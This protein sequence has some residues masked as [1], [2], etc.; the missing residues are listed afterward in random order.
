MSKTLNQKKMK[1][2]S[3]DYENPN[4]KADETEL[5]EL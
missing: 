4:T 3:V 5:F 1:F 2:A